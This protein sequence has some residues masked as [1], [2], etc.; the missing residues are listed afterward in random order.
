MPARNRMPRPLRALLI[1]N[2]ASGQAGSSPQ[3]LADILS[4]IQDRNILSEVY[5]VHRNGDV[6]RT[7]RRAVKD[8]VKLVVVAGGDGTIDRVAGALVGSSATLAIIPT[9]TRNNV[10]FN[11]GIPGTPAE[12]VSLLRGGRGLKIDVGSVTIGRSRRWFLEAASLCLISDMY[13]AADELQHGN[14]E[15][16]GTLFSAF[17]AST[18]ASLRAVLGDRQR[19]DASAYMVLITN[20]P[21]LGPRLQFAPHISCRDGRLDMFIFSD[22]S[23]LDLISFAVRS[24]AGPVIDAHVRH[25]RLTKVR[26]GSTPPMPV[27]ADGVP[28]GLGP[29]TVQVHPRSLSVLVGATGPAIEPVAASKRRELDAG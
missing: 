3:Q 2:P 27:L 12:A 6:E 21:Y 20:M 16:I 23:K 29:V 5:M 28:L 7:V 10:A 1:F 9:G 24:A 18:P 11:L 14:L 25:L 4:A 22:M 19:L 13:P 26:I 8:G 15:Q 17:V